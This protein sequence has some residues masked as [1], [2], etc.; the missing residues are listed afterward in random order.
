MFPVNGDW[1]NRRPSR[2]ETVGYYHATKKCLTN[3]FLFFSV[4]YVEISKDVKDSLR[5]SHKKY[6]TSEFGLVPQL[7]YNS[8]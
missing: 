8:F 7:P 3:R 2:Q 1:S 4:D 6:L 5:D